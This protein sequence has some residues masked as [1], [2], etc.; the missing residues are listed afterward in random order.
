MRNNGQ[1]HRALSMKFCSMK[2]VE[3]ILLW[4]R[5]SFISRKRKKK[6][7]S[8]KGWM[9]IKSDLEKTYDHLS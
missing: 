8:L 2:K 3:T 1:D 6:K 5:K 9:T 4:R 7:K